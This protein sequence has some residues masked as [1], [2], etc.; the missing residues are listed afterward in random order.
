MKDGKVGF[1]DENGKIAI[2]F[3]YEIVWSSDGDGRCLSWY[4]FSYG[5]VAAVKKDGKWGLI[6]KKGENKT[7]FKYDWI[8]SGGSGGRFTA[9]LNNRDVFL[10][11]GGNE[12]SSEEERSEKSDSI[13]AVQGYPY[14]QF[15]M[16]KP[17]YKAKDYAKAYPWFVKSAEGGND[18]GQCHLG[19]Y[20]Y[21]GY[22]PINIR[23]YSLAFNWFSKAALQGNE[24]A[25]YFLGWMYEHGQGV[26]KDESKALEW[27]K[28]SN[29]QRNAKERIKALTK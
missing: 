20:Y 2:P 14:E 22:E 6:N 25:C 27:Y 28:K 19:Y 23:K 10:D 5:N 17:Y 21:Y 26:F 29:G 7:E 18:D 8:S 13:L 1:I 11:K 16:G 4:D 3:I 12:Y 24:D 9:K 15:K